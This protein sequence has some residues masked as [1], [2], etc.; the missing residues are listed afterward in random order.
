MAAPRLS[1][2]I[3]NWR[4]DAALEKALAG[5]RLQR[6][7]PFE[8][9]VVSDRVDPPPGLTDV[10]WATVAEPNVSLARNVGLAQAAGDWIAFLDDDAVPEPDWL[11]QLS[12]H[13]ES[14]LGAVGGPVLGPNGVRV[15]WGRLDLDETG[16]DTA[17]GTGLCAKLSGTNMIVN[18]AALAQVGGFDAR[19]AYFHDDTDLTIRLHKAGWQIG[20]A[21]GAVVHHGYHPSHRRGKRGLPQSLSDIGTSTAAYLATHVEPS[22]HAT[23][24]T[25]VYAREQRRLS[26]LHRLGLIGGR[27][28]SSLLK[29]LQAAMEHPT[30]TP[31][32]APAHPPTSEFTPFHCHR[33]QSIAILPRIYN[34]NA[35]R[36]DAQKLASLGHTVTLI[37]MRYSPRP[38]AV[39]FAGHWYHLGGTFALRPDGLSPKWRVIPSAEAEMQRVAHH[40][41]FALALTYTRGGARRWFTVPSDGAPWQSLTD[42]P[43]DF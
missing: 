41:T 39:S 12:T 22:L 10:K 42:A 24:K 26:K 2:I 23:A 28:L 3:P 1:V 27:R 13:I 29:E 20:W 7:V 36:R 16:S 5:L 25:G 38:Q 9:I 35:A 14:G 21:E 32:I 19:F 30:T 40:R 31:K 34:R 4:R 15:Q 43:F 11:S 6:D 37:E 33:G 8:V 17:P 18:R